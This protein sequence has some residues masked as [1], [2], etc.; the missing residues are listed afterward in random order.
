MTAANLEL[1]DNLDEALPEIT[2]LLPIPEAVDS[3]EENDPSFG[4]RWEP[5]R[6]KER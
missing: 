5:D 4:W 6:P 2:R 3:P 1:K